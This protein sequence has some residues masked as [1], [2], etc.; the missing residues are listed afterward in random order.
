MGRGVRS[1]IAATV[2]RVYTGSMG[3][4]SRIR[5]A[6]AILRAFALRTGRLRVPVPGKQG[7]GPRGSRVGHVGAGAA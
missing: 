6:T 3:E 4:A 7:P 2:Q 1:R 5:E